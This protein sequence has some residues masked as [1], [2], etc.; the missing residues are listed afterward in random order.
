MLEAMKAIVVCDDGVSR[1]FLRRLFMNLKEIESVIE[2]DNPAHALAYARNNPVAFAVLGMKILEV[3]QFNLER[4]HETVIAS[5]LHR[6]QNLI[7]CRIY[8]NYY[9]AWIQFL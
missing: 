1:R 9:N 3:D 4:N 5:I 8:V 2:F 6:L 7:R